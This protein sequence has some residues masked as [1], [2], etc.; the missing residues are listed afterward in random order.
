MAMKKKAGKPRVAG[1][2]F[3]VIGIGASAGG[4]EALE[5]FLSKIPSDS[6]SAFIVIQHLSPDHETSMDSILHKHTDM[7]VAK[8]EDG[9]A[10]QKNHVY[11][12]P[13]NKQ[14]AI[15][16]RT[17]QLFEQDAPGRMNLPIDYFFQSLAQDQCE[18]A[19]G[20]ILSGTGTD[21]SQGIKAIK[22]QGGMTIAQDKKQAKYD[23]MPGSAIETG[24][25]DIVL[26]AEQMAEEIIRYVTHPYYHPDRKPVNESELKKHVQKI[27]FLIMKKTGHDFKNYKQ[28]TVRRR[29]EKRMALH[30]IEKIEDY[31]RFI[32]RESFEVDALFKEMLIGVTGFFRE[33]EMFEFLGEKVLPDLLNQLPPDSSFRVWVPGCATGE[34]AFSLAMIILEAMDALQKHVAI[35]IFASDIDPDAIE[36][37]RRA[38]YP[39][40]I[41]AGVS[42]QRLKRFFLESNGSYLVKKQIRDMVIFAVQ[43]VIKDPP[44]SKL[45]L[46]SCCNL[47]IYLDAQVQGRV[48]PLFHY[49]LK[50]NGVLVLGPSESIG[51]HADLFSPINAKMKIYRRK[52]GRAENIFLPQGKYTDSWNEQAPVLAPLSDLHDSEVRKLVEKL[53]VED[54]APPS[55]L[56]NDMYQI[57]YFIGR[58]D[59]YITAPS[60]EP[61]FNLLRMMREDVRH[62][63][64]PALHRA[65]SQKSEVRV[66]NVRISSGGE[67]ARYLNIIITPLDETFPQQ[68][69]FLVVFESAPLSPKKSAAGK[70]TT[71]RRKT[72]PEQA[73]LEQDLQSTREQLQSAIEQFEVAHEEF[74][75]TNEELQSMNEEL[76]STIEELETSKEELQST[77]EELFTVNSELQN[78]VEELSVVNNDINNLLASTEIGI[79]FLDGRL[80]IKRYNPEMTKIF[81]LI[82]SD[83]G[84]PISDITS[85]IIYDGLPGDAKAVLDT[86]AR[87]NAEV[88][89]RSGRW[90][91]MSILPYRTLDNIIDGVVITFVD[92][93]RMKTFE[94]DSENARALAESIVETMTQPLLILDSDLMVIKAS[95]SY[96]EMFKI[97]PDDIIGRRLY[98][99][100]S[101]AWDLPGLR[102]LLEEIIPHD[103]KI[104]QYP[105]TYN[106]VAGERA[107]LML[108][109]CRIE[110]EGNRQALILLTIEVLPE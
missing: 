19:I 16:N 77:N 22:A 71:R 52:K 11:V 59:R 92:N 27:L 50:E 106:F 8:I 54:Y 69:L 20:I 32:Q 76:Q 65:V 28:N 67:G 61:S 85:N 62:K 47:L 56:I 58:T 68:N 4:L 102:K 97:L 70:K 43:N 103:K 41:A 15:F 23:G 73:I 90:Y 51:A 5:L 53:V 84:R 57:L 66:E 39:E 12:N 60:G 80:C 7:E 10:V 74:K 30:H 35:Q 99:A 46:V 34:E 14:I 107:T 63:L 104:R 109:A 1:T 78:K 21:G 29:I 95:R 17:F 6:G 89:D 64:T 24:Y 26:K 2:G 3:P 48:I 105:V 33:Q 93:T 37:A 94:I 110:Q 101:Q 38:M 79:M 18:R 55:V 81:N 75:S 9:M 31:V 87:K 98:D 72:D 45:D 108:N 40:S 86:L 49:T 82:Q 100:N 44:F 83:I 13:P 91:A 36:F 88:Q 42:P 96:Y 25:I